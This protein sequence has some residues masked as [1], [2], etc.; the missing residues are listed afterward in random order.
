MP[1]NWGIYIFILLFI[2]F[3]KCVWLNSHK[4]NAHMMWL[5]CTTDNVKA[6]LQWEMW[7]VIIPG[8]MIEMLEPL[9]IVMSAI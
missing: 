4:L 1:R 7:L 3:S 6:Q 5:H 9:Y 2:Y 8:S